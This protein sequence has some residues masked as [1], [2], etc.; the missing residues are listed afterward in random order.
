MGV[1]GQANWQVLSRDA[2]KNFFL[3]VW[4]LY[5]LL[6]GIWDQ[7]G[8]SEK[9]N[10]ATRPK[11]GQGLVMVLQGGEYSPTIPNSLK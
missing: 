10:E 4:L 9:A 8:W 5:F 3:R 2:Q 11:Q 7:K 6:Q 1:R